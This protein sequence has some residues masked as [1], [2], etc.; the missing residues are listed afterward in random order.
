MPLKVGGS[1]FADKFFD[2][3][4]DAK[5]LDIAVGYITA[6]SLIELQKIV[7]FNN[8]QRLNLIIGMHYLEKFTK[9][10]YRAAMTLNSFLKENDCGCVKLVTPFKYHG[11]IYTYSNNDKPVSGI[12][13]SNNLSSIIDSNARTY[14]ASVYIQEPDA[15]KNMYSFVSELSLKAADDIDTLDIKEFKEGNPLLEGH[16]HVEKIIASELEHVK[17]KL[18]P[19]VSFD[20]PIKGDE[21]C[22]K[23]NLN[24]YFGEGRVSPNGIIKPR[25]WYEVELIVSKTITSMQGYPQK[26]TKEAVFDV[27]TDDGWKFKCKISGT[28][29][30]NFRSENDLKIL[31]K[32]IKGRLE[33]EGV[34]KIGESVTH[35]ML[36]EYGRDNLTFTKTAIPNTWY[37]DFGVK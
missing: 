34:L 19:N 7:E 32:W 33:N 8:I 24:V 17:D 4:V 25:H 13:G 6:D 28:N 3:M 21:S 11:K 5:Q 20:I 12:I 35:Q 30:K 2:A 18:I 23:S 36:M 16:E 1:T 26:D 31:G 9:P 29:S 14:E 37:L 27:V 22:P 15:V 10:E